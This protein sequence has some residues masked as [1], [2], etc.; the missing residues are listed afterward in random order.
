MEWIDIA[1]LTVVLVSGVIGF[2]KGF[3]RE[4]ILIVAIILGVILA[5]SFAATPERWVPFKA[6]TF[7][8][9]TIT[10]H[11]LSYVISFVT[12]VLGT[13]LIGQMLASMLTSFYESKD[14][15]NNFLGWNR[16]F[17][18]LFG[19]VRGGLIV[20]VLV[21]LAGLTNLPELEAWKAADTLFFFEDI[22]IRLIDQL[23]SDYSRHFLLDDRRE[24]ANG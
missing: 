4:F 10:T 19:I 1:I 3:I 8:G 21:A 11:N 13:L 14:S 16:L 17:G 6:W 18:F 23:P 22:A 12:I 24:A 5:F 7:L 2:L 15:K 20:V 9:Q